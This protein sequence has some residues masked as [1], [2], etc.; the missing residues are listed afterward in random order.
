MVTARQVNDKKAQLE[1]ELASINKDIIYRFPVSNYLNAARPN[2]GF[3]RLLRFHRVRKLSR[4]F[5]QITDRH[6]A[7]A[8]SVYLK[9][10][11][12]CFIGDSLER[13]ST[14]NLP[15]EIVRLYNEWFE[16]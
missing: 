7:R 1:N 12:C 16:T 15:G 3:G 5:R 13:L 9:L 2:T 10:A 8:L 4:S 11:L 14:E 6:G